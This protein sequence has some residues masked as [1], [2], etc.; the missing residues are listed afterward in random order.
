MQ[1][2]FVLR[3][4]VP[5]D[6]HALECMRE[7]ATILLHETKHMSER[8]TQAIV[9]VSAKGMEYGAV[10]QNALSKEKE[11]ETALMEMLSLQG[12]TEIRYVLCMW[13]DGGID[14]PS[15]AFRQMLLT[16][17][18]KNA[19]SVLLLMT[20]NGVQGVQLSKTMK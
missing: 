9:L 11:D 7:R 20:D 18:P 4:S 2:R 3:A 14:V 13:E 12:D 6:E 1:V 10:I 19:E 15:M 17:D 5:F 8:Y 16:L